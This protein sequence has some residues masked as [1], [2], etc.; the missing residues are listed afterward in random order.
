MN[1]H[2]FPMNENNYPET[3]CSIKGYKIFIKKYETIYFI[4]YVIR[5]I[6]CTNTWV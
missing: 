4:Y 2:R 1:L 5:S 3:K 6:Q